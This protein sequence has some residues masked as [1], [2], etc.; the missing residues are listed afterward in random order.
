MQDASLQ[1]F[2]TASQAFCDERRSGLASV[3]I[4]VV[5]IS[6][7][8]SSSDDRLLLLQIKRSTRV[9]AVL[10]SKLAPAVTVEKRNS[11]ESREHCVTFDARRVWVSFCMGRT[12]VWMRWNAMRARRSN[13]QGKVPL[14]FDFERLLKYSFVFLELFQHC[15]S[16]RH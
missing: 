4:S 14:G 8:A 7:S 1:L 6:A 10:Q 12:C 2:R 9:P 3:S 5:K 15:I 16:K 11:M 13:I